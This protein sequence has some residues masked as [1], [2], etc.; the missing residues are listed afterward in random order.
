MIGHAERRDIGRGD[1]Q[2]RRHAHFRDRDDG[3][4]DHG[5]ADLAALQNLGDGSAHLFADAQHAL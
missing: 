2:I 4:L 5:I 3:L 1:L